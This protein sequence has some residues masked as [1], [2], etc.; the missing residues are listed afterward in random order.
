[1]E[2]KDINGIVPDIHISVRKTAI[3]GHDMNY[4]S[5]IIDFIHKDLSEWRYNK[6]AKGNVE[7]GRLD[8]VIKWCYSEIEVK[9]QHEQ[10]W[11]G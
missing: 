5:T 4:A 11:W 3:S 7:I 10:R 8:E 6:Y 9:G 1:M 2:L